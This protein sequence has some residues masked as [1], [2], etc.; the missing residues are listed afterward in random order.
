MNQSRYQDSEEYDPNLNLYAKNYYRADEM[1][2]Y[3]S[4][5]AF[6]GQ[7]YGKEDASYYNEFDYYLNKVEEKSINM[8]VILQKN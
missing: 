1:S 2:I 3:E 6:L 8:V 5:Q 7:A 4:Y